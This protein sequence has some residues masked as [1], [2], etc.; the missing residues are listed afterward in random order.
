MLD[1]GEEAG[2]VDRTIEHRRCGE[3]FQPQGGN[4]GLCVPVTT[5]C[6]V[7]EADAAGTSAV[8]AQQ[9]RRHAAFIDK[10]ILTRIAERE[11]RSPL[12]PLRRDISPSLFVGVYGFF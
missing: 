3:P 7:M 2:I 4:E 1:V 5:G 9:I 6:V 10:D 12:P 11:P 8:P